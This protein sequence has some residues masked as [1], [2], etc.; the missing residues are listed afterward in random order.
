M[1]VGD[2]LANPLSHTPGGFLLGLAAYDSWFAAS[3]STA[4]AANQERLI[5]DEVILAVDLALAAQGVLP[6]A[7]EAA[8][9]DMVVGDTLANPLSHTPGGFLLGLAAYDAAATAPV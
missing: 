1:V 4:A 9:L 8:A 3:P 5:Q 2:T 7:A 6:P